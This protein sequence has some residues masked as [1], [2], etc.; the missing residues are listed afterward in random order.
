MTQPHK[1]ALLGFSSF[2]RSTFESFFRLAARRAP[3]YEIVTDIASAAMV[4]VNS[5]DMDVLRGF[6]PSS[7]QKVMLVGHGDGGTGW[8]LQQRPIK[9]MAV[10]TQVDQT[11][12]PLVPTPQTPPARAT[13]AAA[14]MQRPQ[15][16]P[17][18]V[19]AMPAP[20]ISSKLARSVREGSGQASPRNSEAGSMLGLETRP[21]ESNSE[22]YD[23]IL[24]VDDS[25]IALKFMQNRLQRFGFRAHLVRSGEEALGRLA[26]QPYK[27][28]FLDVMM[29]GLDGYQTCRAIKQRKYS[30][31]K[32]P[33]VVM[34]TSRGGTI[35]KIRGTLAGCDAYLTKPLNETEL[36]KVLAKHDHS[37][38]RG[39]RSTAVGASS[40]AASSKAPGVGKA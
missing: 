17:P 14:P 23:D 19:V 13:A 35:D 37:I 25:D 8:P 36:I 10:L 1:I 18:S 31:G 11:L 38:E 26:Q 33:V 27:F 32:A 21:M 16:A 9:L 30:S 40:F 22:L 15:P 2:E 3:G 34:L 39:F 4:I 28:V 20:E 5:D 29:D 7:A 24:V 12:N 6:K